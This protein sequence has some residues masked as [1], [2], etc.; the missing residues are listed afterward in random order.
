MNFGNVNAV[1][2][3]IAFFVPGFVASIVLGMTFRSHSRSV[4]DRTLQYLTLSCFNYGLWS[5]LIV[6]L[7]YMRWPEHHPY[8]AGALVVLIVFLSPLGLTLALIALVR[9]PTVQRFL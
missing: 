1:L 5:W 8:L 7:I 3:A 6:P 4:G 2:I 9:K